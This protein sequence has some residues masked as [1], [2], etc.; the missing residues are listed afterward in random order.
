[1]EGDPGQLGQ[2]VMNLVINAA[3]AMEGRTGTLRVEV[4]RLDLPG[5]APGA[6]GSRAFLRVADQG[7]GMPAEQR[8]R[9]FDPLFTTR[10]EGRGLGLA[11]VDAVVRAHGGAVEVD[12]VPGE[13]STFRVLL[14]L[15]AAPASR[16]GAPPGGST[17]AAGDQVPQRA[18]TTPP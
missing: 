13:G 8:A 14:P 6:A 4:G 15:A 18:T 17:P 7:V 12:S 3:Q 10:A 11:I 9:I 5:Q 16:A 1:V 2:V